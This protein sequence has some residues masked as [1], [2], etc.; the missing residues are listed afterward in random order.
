MCNPR[1][2]ALRLIF[3]SFLTFT[4]FNPILVKIFNHKLFSHLTKI[5]DRASS[6]NSS[7]KSSGRA[8]QRMSERMGSGH[9][10]GYD[11]QEEENALKTK[12]I[13]NAC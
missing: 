12:E 8:G 9:R 6:G 10:S 1:N 2:T 11:L 4:H 3:N 7:R 5:A 13:G